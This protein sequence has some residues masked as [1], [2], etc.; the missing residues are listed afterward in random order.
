[1]HEPGSFRPLAQVEKQG[2]TTRLHYIVTD[3]TGASLVIEPQDG[4]LKV[5]DNPL[6]VVTNSPSFD[7][8]LTNLRNYVNLHPENVP[9]LKI[10][11]VMVHPLGNGSGMHGIPGDATP[12]SRFVKAAAYVLSTQ[13]VSDG[14]QGVRLVEHIM[15]NFDIPKGLILDEKTPPEYTQWTSVADLGEDRYYI[16]TWEVPVLHGVGF[17]DFDMDGTAMV[18]F[19]L[20]TDG[21]PTALKQAS[22][23]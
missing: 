14:P 23:S 20:P 5:Y 15:N 1:M 8:H 7:W 9:P 3:L 17:S 21:T 10:G 12:P 19:P 11:N 6:G 22:A 13:R 16:K 2:D 4:R 18:R